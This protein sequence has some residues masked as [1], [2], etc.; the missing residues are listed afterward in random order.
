MDIL[1]VCSIALDT[2][3]SVDHLPI[4][5]SFCTVLKTQKAQGG[6]GTNVLVQS[7]RVGAQTGVV[8]KIAM[9][10]DSD[11]ILRNLKQVGIDSRGVYRQAGQYAAPHCLIY[12][13]PEGEKPLIL[14]KLT[15]LPP[16]NHAEADLSLIDET[17]VV[18]VDLCPAPLGLEV[19]KLAKQKGK[20]VVLN[21]QDNMDTV[22]ARH[23]T[24][25]EILDALQYLDVFAPCQEGIK[26]LSG[27]TEVDQQIAFIRQYYQGLIILTLGARGLVAVDEQ[28]QRYDIPAYQLDAVDTTGAGDAFIGSFM[29]NYL[30]QKQP[31]EAALKFA[32]SCAAYTCLDFGAQASPTTKQVQAF[33]NKYQLKSVGR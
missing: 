31:L 19:M 5:D 16:L 29:A 30:V 14:D 13:D 8:T 2:L 15:E 22:R 17:Q 32:T 12:I 20:Q 28:D 33:Q 9:D 4:K 18:Y 7:Q 27:E 10:A 3:S 24:D 1:G 23:V 26:G 6:S 25:E 11:Q 21:I